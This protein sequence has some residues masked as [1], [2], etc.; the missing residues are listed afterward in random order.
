MYKYVQPTSIKS[1]DEVISGGMLKLTTGERID[2]LEREILALRKQKFDGV[3]IT[4]PK[5][6]KPAADR[7]K[8][9]LRSW[10]KF[11]RV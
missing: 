5:G 10:L 7:G 1:M 9:F 6:F 11:L 4:H 2:K 3:E 8:C